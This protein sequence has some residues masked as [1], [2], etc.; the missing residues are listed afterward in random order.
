MHL[1]LR[2][3]NKKFLFPILGVFVL[4]VLFFPQSADALFWIPAIAGLSILGYFFGD[5]LLSFAAEPLG[6]ALAYF[7]TFVF[8]LIAG[9]LQTIYMALAGLMMKAVVYFASIPVDPSQVPIVEAGWDFTR[10]LANGFFL[11]IL[12]FIGLAT[13]LRLQSYQLQR[14]LPLLIIAALLINFSGVFVSVIVDIGNLFTNFFLQGS[15]VGPFHNNPWGN[16]PPLKDADLGNVAIN[17]AR[18]LY[19]LFGSLLF[20]VILLIFG[21]RIIILWTIVILAPIAF[22]SIILPF[23]KK[24][25]QRWLG[26]LMEWAFIGVP[27]AFFMYLAST[28]LFMDIPPDPKNAVGAAFL[29]SLAPIAALI[30]LFL[31]TMFSVGL[32]GSLGGRF[33]TALQRAPGKVWRSKAGSKFKGNMAGLANK[34]I[35][36]LPGDFQDY[37]TRLKAG[38]EKAK[39][40]FAKFAMRNAGSG[41]G[42]V[43]NATSKVT[44]FVERPLMEAE[45]RNR[46]LALPAGFEKWGPQRQAKWIS[47]LMF[48]SDRVQAG[49][50]IADNGTLRFTPDAFKAQYNKD[51]DWAKEKR[52]DFYQEAIIAN[53][54]T[55]PEDLTEREELQWTLQKD[56]VSKGLSD[57]ILK[58]FDKKA[59]RERELTQ[60][61]ERGETLT[62]AEK[63]EK[64]K[65]EGLSED[66]L[67]GLG[68]KENQRK[69]LSQ[70]IREARKKNKEARE[71]IANALH[72][73]EEDG[74]DIHVGIDIEYGVQHKI[75]TR[76]LAE[77]DRAKAVDEVR[78]AL[79]KTGKMPDHE[80]RGRDTFLRDSAATK[81]AVRDERSQYIKNIAN[82]DGDNLGLRSG[83]AEGPSQHLREI[84]QT[85]G[86]EAVLDVF[87]GAGGIN[88]HIEA[89]VDHY[90]LKSSQMFGFLQSPLG[91]EYPSEARNYMKD[92]QGNFTDQQNVHRNRLRVVQLAEEDKV[93]GEK[94]S[95]VGFYYA[96]LQRQKAAQSNLETA[97]ANRLPADKINE[98]QKAL[99]EVEQ[100]IERVQKYYRTKEKLDEPLRQKYGIKIMPN[101]EEPQRKRLK[102]VDRLWGTTGRG[103]GPAAGG[104]GGGTSGRVPG[105]DYR[106]GEGEALDDED[107][108]LDGD[109]GSDPGNRGPR[110]G[111]T[112]GGARF[113]GG[114]GGLEDRGP[115]PASS[116]NDAP[117][118][119]PDSG[120]R[121]AAGPKGIEDLRA[122]QEREKA[123]SPV[124]SSPRPTKE[125]SVTKLVERSKRLEDELAYA[126]EQLKITQTSEETG[127]WEQEM[128]RLQTE[129][130]GVRRRREELTQRTTQQPP[131]SPSISD[132]ELRQLQS[133]TKP[134]KP[135]N[136]GQIQGLERLREAAQKV[137]TL[138]GDLTHAKEQLR[139]AETSEATGNWEQEAAR[140]RAEIG[141]V[142]L[143]REEIIRQTLH[144][145]ER[146]GLQ[147]NRG[148]EIPPYT[149]KSNVGKTGRDVEELKQ[150]IRQD[151]ADLRRE[152]LTSQEDKDILD[153]RKRKGK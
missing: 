5:D 97:R 27:I 133:L 106:G 121:F 87:N 10:G 113:A 139:T 24:W 36:R 76:E 15:L 32:A 148:Q 2:F 92:V 102:D 67:K 70:T 120:A 52:D 109:G 20:F 140:L 110:A 59:A 116:S 39:N 122:P 71:D 119:D 9:L 61:E 114:P 93:E 135:L 130:A 131:E 62:E 16:M 150:T 152:G 101:G 134:K 146:T 83:L 86:R 145:E 51:I 123:P 49:K 79:T 108:D 7:A 45:E 95:L 31:G 107:E 81:V 14:T 124:P 11:L 64:K 104:R 25:W 65:A 26:A 149:L 94:Q 138:E 126:K 50:I 48:A 38:A 88:D 63:E 141:E 46:K 34:G 100:E 30:L 18:I 12:A 47:S 72:K 151:M 68:V 58:E 6:H 19:F 13:I 56:K 53:R 69:R 28:I 1:S 74:D 4:A 37:S 105:D 85:H 117:R 153:R 22:A 90:A 80:K 84:Q 78:N 125:E 8:T 144:L 41:F 96:A 57:K 60:K 137:Q 147:E 40:P 89:D 111:G 129:I 42:A 73:K 35:S 66:E 118:R 112:P 77:S 82:I 54:R 132:E 43:G 44:G 91:R 115:Q 142:R 17:V 3:A 98:S 103:A 143:R 33:Q 75:I 55:R 99:T 128:A 136:E 23:T 29:A 127:N 21:L